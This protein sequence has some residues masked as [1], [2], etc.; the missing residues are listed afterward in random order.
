MLAARDTEHLIQQIGKIN[1]LGIEYIQFHEPDI[2]NELTAFAFYAETDKSI[3]L[4]SSLPLTLKD[5]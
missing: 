2:D 3:K 5:K 4:F 1:K